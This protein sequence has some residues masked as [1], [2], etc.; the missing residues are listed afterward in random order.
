MYTE[1]YNFR[2][3]PFQITPDHRFFFD[4]RPH[5]KAA[6]YLTYGLSQG[7]G[8]IVITG[9]IGAGKTTLVNHMLS[10]IQGPDRVT[11]KVVTTQ[12]EAD[13]FMRVIASAF[14]IE[15]EGL[16]KATILRRIESFLKQC[17]EQ[18]KRAL[19]FVDE[20]QNVPPS[21]L[22]ELRMLSNFQV[23]EK[24]LLQIFLV[25]Q[26]QFRHTL[27]SEDLEQLRQ[28]V[29]AT[30][31]LSGLDNDE[32]RHYIE[33][34]LRRVE[35][36]DD[37]EISDDAFHMVFE[38]TNGVPRRINLLCDRLLLFGYLEELHRI[39][40][41]AVREVALDMQTEGIPTMTQRP[42]PGGPETPALP[43]TAPH[44]NQYPHMPQPMVPQPAMM[45]QPMMN[46]M[47]V[48]LDRLT[49]RIE[50]VERL[51]RAQDDILRRVLQRSTEQGRKAEN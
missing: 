31:H 21:S 48:E 39:D 51:V 36:Q 35:W 25:G 33:H 4:S 50:A 5:S 22:E 10:Q 46:P 7:E 40:V 6:A 37:P 32:T 18:G 20:V 44:P 2:G 49:Q 15:Q 11:A 42:V 27:I 17:H 26:P 29:I 41:S 9:E 19:L 23:E 1:F 30:Y 47:T 8:F 13:N 3:L 12:F 14:G 45:H 38:I 28:R 43:A 24:S 34:R 16:D